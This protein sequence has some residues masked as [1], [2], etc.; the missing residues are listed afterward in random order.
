MFRSLLFH[1]PPL[2][3]SDADSEGGEKRQE[4]QMVVSG[5]LGETQESH[6]SHTFGG[7][8]RSQQGC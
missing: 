1:Y 6:K 4:K 7:G 8:K 5:D 3:K 2:K